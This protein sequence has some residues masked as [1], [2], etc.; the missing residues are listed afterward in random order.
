VLHPVSFSPTIYTLARWVQSGTRHR[1]Q[2]GCG[3]VRHAGDLRWKP[4]ANAGTSDQSTVRPIQ[5]GGPTRFKSAL[6]SQPRRNTRCS[7]F[8]SAVAIS[9]RQNCKTHISCTGW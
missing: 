9:R 3:M 2:S 7:R 6:I 8:G 5:R 1:N 4:G